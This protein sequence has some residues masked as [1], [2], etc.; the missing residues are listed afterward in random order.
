MPRRMLSPVLSAL[1]EP[2]FK[3]INQDVIIII[4]RNII[5]TNATVITFTTEVSLF[6]KST[7]YESISSYITIRDFI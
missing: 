5:T 3:N 1:S 4:E 6:V 7:A 2:F